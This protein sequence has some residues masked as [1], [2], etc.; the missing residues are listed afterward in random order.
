[1]TLLEALSEELPWGFIADDE[2]RER[3]LAG[4]MPSPPVGVEENVW[5][6]VEAMCDPDQAARPD[7]NTVVEELQ[8]LAVLL[9]PWRGF[10]VDVTRAQ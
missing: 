6:L 8:A 7:V 10:L 3:V 1:M 4:E 5:S 9:D 2:V